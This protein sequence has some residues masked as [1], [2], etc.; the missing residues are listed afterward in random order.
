MADAPTLGTR[1]V[2][3][4]EA[5][6]VLFS[7]DRNEV[8]RIIDACSRPGP[9]ASQT[10]A[11]SVDAIYAI[12]PRKDAPRAAKVAIQNAANRLEAREADPLAFLMERTRLYAAAVATWPDTLRFTKE[13]R[14]TVP[15]PTTWFNQDRFDA[16]PAI[17]SRGVPE[18][19]AARNYDKI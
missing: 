16:N 5:A 18:K 3:E 12:Y 10:E 6:G 14:D 7:A 9:A 11:L 2:A 17:W 4:L 19:P 13:G 8:A 15:M 1:A